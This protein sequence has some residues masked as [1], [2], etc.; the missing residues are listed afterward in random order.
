MKQTLEST[1]LTSKFLVSIKLSFLTKKTLLFVLRFLE[2]FLGSK[3][4][5]SLPE[6]LVAF[7]NFS[8]TKTVLDTLLSLKKQGLLG[9][10]EKID[11]IYEDEPSAFCYRTFSQFSSST[12]YRA[13]GHGRDFFSEEKAMWRAIGEGVERTLWRHHDFFS[14]KKIKKTYTD[15]TRNSLNIHDLAGFSE[16]QKNKY[17]FLRF[18]ENTLFEWIP[19]IDLLQNKTVFAPLQLFS[20]LYAHHNVRKTSSDTNTSKE[21]LLRWCITTGLA[22]GR[23]LNEALVAGILE[24]IERDAFMISYLNKISVP[25]I[26]LNIL[27]SQD[28]EI[29]FV[30]EKFK[31]YNLEVHVVSLLTDFPVSVNLAFIIDRTGKSPFIGFGASAD[32]SLKR[33]VLSAI[34]EAHYVRL[35]V[36]RIY[37]Q[38]LVDLGQVGRE[39]RLIY[40]AQ[41]KDTSSFDFLMNGK[42]VQPELTRDFSFEKKNSF[43]Y[44]NEDFLL[45]TTELRK[46]GLKTYYAELSPKNLKKFGLYTVNVSIPKLQPLHLE[47]RVPYFGGE[48]LTSIPTELGYVPIKNLNTEP[49]PFP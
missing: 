21:P 12:G 10:I 9:G 28:E 41:K 39:E 22:T 32:F 8:D 19:T 24:I 36:R 6:P 37:H 45:L 47:E 26:D 16:E 20:A 44:T 18:S 7:I 48:R 35:G 42:V 49:H 40:W 4:L 3:L 15:V 17:D 34:T 1:V 11:R 2:K 29:R 25:R 13:H 5:V 38:K 43:R 14:E 30:L 23:S 27:S 31:K 46:K 33:S